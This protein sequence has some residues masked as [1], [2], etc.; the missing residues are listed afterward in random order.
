MGLEVMLLLFVPLL[1]GAQSC[2]EF[3]IGICQSEYEE[4][5]Y[6]CLVQ[7]EDDPVCTS[8]CR[9]ELDTNLENCPCG[10]NCPQGCPCPEY[11]C[12]DYVLTLNTRNPKN[13]PLVIDSTGGSLAVDFTFDDRTES[14]G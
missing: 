6:S 13:E 5:Y 7:C 4:N 3:Q 10:A 9:R 11:T 2:D 14:H 12:H 1:V 8:Q